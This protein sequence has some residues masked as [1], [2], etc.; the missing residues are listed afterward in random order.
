MP[1]IALLVLSNCFMTVA[2]TAVR[3]RRACAFACALATA[4][5]SV[6]GK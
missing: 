6:V 5:F 3:K 4:V 1:T 2:V